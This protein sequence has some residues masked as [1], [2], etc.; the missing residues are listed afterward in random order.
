MTASRKDLHTSYADFSDDD[1][2]Q[3]VTEEVAAR[4]SELLQTK[5]IPLLSSR[6]QFHLADIIECVGM[7]EKHR[8]S[9]DDNAG[10]FLLFFRAHA[11]SNAQAPISWREI[12]WAFHSQS[13]DILVDLV[14]RHFSGK[15]LWQH[16]KE[17]GMFMWM[18]DITAL[19]S[20]F[21]VLPAT[22]VLTTLRS[23]HNLRSSLAMST[24]KL[25]T[26]TLWIVVYT[27][28]PSKRNQYYLVFGEWR[29]GAESR[30]PHINS[31][32]TTLMKNGGKQQL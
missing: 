30:K 28:W 5:Q 23:V 29:R 6:E 31:C 3:S 12:T 14:S 21:S 9:I 11:L 19:V 26:E 10:R 2:P 24:L 8:R 18:T 27:I 15:M 13:Q 25:K 1:E 16:A 22:C 20:T 32:Q 4:L 17:S 7:V